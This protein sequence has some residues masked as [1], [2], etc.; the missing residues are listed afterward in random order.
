MLNVILD[1]SIDIEMQHLFSLP[2]SL[3]WC[4]TV[5]QI[6]DLHIAAKREFCVTVVQAELKVLKQMVIAVSLLSGTHM[7]SGSF[8]H[9]DLIFSAALPLNAQILTLSYCHLKG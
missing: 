7:F 4:R 9:R 6:V 5:K 8:K 1:T 3:I 2:L